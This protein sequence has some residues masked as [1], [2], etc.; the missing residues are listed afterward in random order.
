M[1]ALR[2]TTIIGVPLVAGLVLSSCSDPLR[3]AEPSWLRATVTELEAVA[4]GDEPETWEF[5]SDATTFSVG[6]SPLT[7]RPAH[8]GVSS[9]Q[10]AEGGEQRMISFGIGH[11]ARIGAGRYAVGVRPSET[12]RYPDRF[13]FV[14]NRGTTERSE[15]YVAVE[16]WVEITRSTPDLVEGTF[17]ITGRQVSLTLAEEG[18]GFQRIFRDDPPHSP[19]PSAPR[20]TIKGSFQARPFRDSEVVPV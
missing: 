20:I 18:R 17:Q 11:P 9:V 5:S 15:R 4:P 3:S 1:Y 6:N 12:G 16:G 8:F 14:F 10:L 2:I 13:S 19:D 7:R